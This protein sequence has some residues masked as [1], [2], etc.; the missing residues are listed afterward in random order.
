MPSSVETNRS[1]HL[2]AGLQGQ[3]YHME[4]LWCDIKL[5]TKLSLVWSPKLFFSPKLVLRGVSSPALCS[6]LPGPSGQ[7]L[8]GLNPTNLV[9]W[10]CPVS[11]T[12]AKIF[13]LS[14]YPQIEHKTG[15]RRSRTRAQRQG[16]FTYSYFFWVALVSYSI[17]HT[18]KK[19]SISLHGTR[20]TP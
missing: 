13:S 19:G 2:I 6:P 15:V 12:S 1:R 8:S 3:L 10:W 11:L 17:M 5:A 20:N 4:I 7:V 14:N 9:N 18:P 16:G